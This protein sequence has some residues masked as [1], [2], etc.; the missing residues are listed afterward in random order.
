MFIFFF[1]F[2]AVL[3]FYREGLSLCVHFIVQPKVVEGSWDVNLRA[4]SRFLPRIRVQLSSKKFTD[5]ISWNRIG[6]LEI[7]IHEDL[8]TRLSDNEKENLFIWSVI[9]AQRRPVFFRILFGSSYAVIDRDVQLNGGEILSFVSMLKSVALFRTEHPPS[10][11]GSLLSGLS[12]LGPGLLGSPRSLED[13]IKD[14]VQRG[15]TA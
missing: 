7:L 2:F 15:Q 6:G 14:V 12:L 1:C 3:F 13:R 11:L 9:S 4:R 10:P 5:A 8:W